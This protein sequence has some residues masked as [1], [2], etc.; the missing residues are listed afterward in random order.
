[1]RF[2]QSE[3]NN[4]VRKIAELHH[5]YK[6]TVCIRDPYHILTQYTDEKYYILIVNCNRYSETETEVVV[7]KCESKHESHHIYLA[8]VANT[9]ELEEKIV[10]YLMM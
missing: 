9:K 1:M 4:V 2:S 5:L 3:W 10:A 7:G 6:K 8:N